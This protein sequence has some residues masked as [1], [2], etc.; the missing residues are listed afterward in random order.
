MKIILYRYLPVSGYHRA[1]GP[2]PA[3]ARHPLRDGV[4]GVPQ[5]KVRARLAAPGGGARCPCRRDPPR[6]PPRH[7]EGR[8]WET[9]VASESARPRGGGIRSGAFRREMRQLS[10]AELKRWFE[11]LVKAL[12]HRWETASPR[13]AAENGTQP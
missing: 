12:L 11:A 9:R 13:S 2:F 5:R 10:Y 8:L 4:S 1:A 3:S 7:V 6:L